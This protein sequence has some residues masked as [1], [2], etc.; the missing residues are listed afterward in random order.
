[1]SFEAV[2]ANSKKYGARL[3]E[4]QLKM[5]QAR[6]LNNEAVIEETI[7][8]NDPNFYRKKKREEWFK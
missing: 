4:L 8:E 7:R 3:Q 2:A 6:A 5:N 1:M